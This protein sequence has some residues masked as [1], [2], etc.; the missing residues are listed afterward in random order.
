[1]KFETQM[2]AFFKKIIIVKKHV[3][4]EF[5]KCIYVSTIISSEFKWLCN[6]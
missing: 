6:N 4:N 5:T 1:M 2:N 3:V